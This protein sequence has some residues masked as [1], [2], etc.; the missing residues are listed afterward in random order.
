VN[1]DVVLPALFSVQQHICRACYMLSSVR[2]SV[3]LS[4][5]LS[6]TWV[7]QSKMV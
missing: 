1:K 6:I 7:D 5:S 3:C 2:L 4:V